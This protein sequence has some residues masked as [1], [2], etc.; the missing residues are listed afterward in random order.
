MA[1]NKKFEIILDE[2][3]ELLLTG[4]GTIEQ[5]LQR[6][7][8][9]AAELKPLLITATSI[10]KAVDVKPSQEFKARA[11]YQMQLLMAGSAP[12]RTSFWSLQPKWVIATMA[13]MVVFLMSGG[14]V[15]AANS[16]MPGSP[17]YPIKIAAENISLQLAGSDIEKA[18]IYAAIAERRVEEMIYVVENGKTSYAVNIAQ[19]YDQTMVALSTLSLSTENVF[20]LSATGTDSFGA[21]ENSLDTSKQASAPQVG[22]AAPSVATGTESDQTGDRTLTTETVTTSTPVPN[23]TLA[24]PGTSTNTSNKTMNSIL[25][26]KD[27]LKQ[28][29]AYNAVYHPEKLQQL[30]DIAP[31][32]IKPLI[33][34]MIENATLD[35]RQI[36]DKLDD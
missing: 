13:V 12:K 14:T 24:T 28:Y 11:H 21:T 29:I 15:L 16:S 4:E 26:D 9:Y 17:L 18:E 32:N 2:C 35:N 7:P 33:R 34:H 27:K 25:T 20:A 19:K 31:E 23:V 8:E 1:K 22:L 6:Y 36:L 3:L 30:L 5:C 10:E